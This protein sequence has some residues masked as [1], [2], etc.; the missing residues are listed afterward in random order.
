MRDPGHILVSSMNQRGGEVGHTVCSDLTEKRNRQRGERKNSPKCV[1]LEELAYVPSLEAQNLSSET[2]G[3]KY[4][5][6]PTYVGKN[7]VRCFEYIGQNLEKNSRLEGKMFVQGRKRNHAQSRGT[8]DSHIR[9][10]LF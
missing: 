6:L 10:G 3:G 9:Y 1:N 5:G 2:F 4:L 8:S 7:R